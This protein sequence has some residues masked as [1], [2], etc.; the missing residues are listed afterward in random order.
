MKKS[1]IS[2]IFLIA[3]L[4]LLLAACG[5]AP[6]ASSWPGITVDEA[7]GTAYVAF[8]QNVFAIQID[9]GAQRWS[10]RPEGNSFQTYA[11]PT[12]TAD[13]Q[14]LVGGYDNILYSLDPAN[15]TQKWAFSGGGNRYVGSALESAGTIYAPN[16]DHRLYAL[17]GNGELQWSF[18]ANEPLWSQPA[19]DGSAVYLAAMDHMLYALD[20]N[21]DL[22]WEQDLGG[23]LIGSPVMSEDGVIYIGTLNKEILALDSGNGRLIWS[24]ATDGW[25]WGA[26]ALVDGQI[27]AGDLEGILYSIDAERGQELWRVT[28]EGEITGTPLVVGENVYVVNENGDVVSVTVE[29]TVR[30]TRNMERPLYG[31]VVQAGDLVLIGMTNVDTI[32]VALDE[33]GTTVWSFIPADN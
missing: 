20:A 1:R 32:V 29:G 6:A 4:G 9:N 19:S 12:L 21:G 28:T 23:T 33:N 18:G 11:P 8:N 10:F 25:V 13:G 7:S 16:S 30:W 17:N 22:L 2:T 27:F 3:L 15:G 26:P 31:S 14:L 24:F 5:G